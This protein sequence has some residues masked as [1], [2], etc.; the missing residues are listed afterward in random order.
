MKVTTSIRSVKKEPH[1]TTIGMM[2]SSWRCTRSLLKCFMFSTQKIL[3]IDAS[4]L[5]LLYSSATTISSWPI[6]TQLEWK[7]I[8]TR[9]RPELLLDKVRM[10]TF[11][12]RN[13]PRQ[14]SATRTRSMSL[15]LGWSWSTW[16]PPSTSSMLTLLLSGIWSKLRVIIQ[17]GSRT[18]QRSRRWLRNVCQKQR[19][20]DLMPLNLAD[21]LKLS[22]V[23]EP[24]NENEMPATKSSHKTTKWSRR[25]V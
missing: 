3:F 5:K 7:M 25:I 14:T 20:R 21:L 24:T 8:L 11:L 10:S 16:R 2:S 19:K 15:A 22:L 13:S 4:T 6:L 12:L 1:K 18:N 23:I 17:A 9:Q